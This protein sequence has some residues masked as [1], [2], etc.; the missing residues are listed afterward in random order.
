M[1]ISIFEQIE[2]NLYAFI[3]GCF[4]WVIYEILKLIRM[5]FYWDF[6]EK[7]RNKMSNK[8]YKRV[9]N[10]LYIKYKH[11]N[12]IEFIV[13]FVF[14][15]AYFAILSI[16]FPTFIYIVN[17]GIFRWY[18]FAS[19]LLGFVIMKITLGRLLNFILEYVN[20]HINIIL[21]LT[22]IP[23]KKLFLKLK[24]VKKVKIKKKKEEK[25]RTVLISYGK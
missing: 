21:Q 15:I 23:I 5:I 4:L 19:A 8:V 20:Y 24:S 22:F 3:L 6:S 1:E 7:F 10:P 9:K 11:K 14:D 16:I 2:A 12:K 25:K 17:S 18:I 13:M